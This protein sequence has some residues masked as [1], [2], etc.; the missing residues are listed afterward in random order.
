MLESIQKPFACDFRLCDTKP[1][2]ERFFQAVLAQIDPDHIFVAKDRAVAGLVFDR[3]EFVKLALSVL[4]HSAAT[5][6]SKLFH[7][8]LG[9]NI[10]DLHKV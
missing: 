4:C 8:G 2:P 6:A 10:F 9:A 5:V 7:I 3:G 1:L